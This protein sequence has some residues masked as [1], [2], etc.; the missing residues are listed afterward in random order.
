[1]KGGFLKG[2]V[3][4]DWIRAAMQLRGSALHVAIFVHFIAGLKS[5]RT[6]KVRL[7]SIPIGRGAASRGLASLERAGLIKVRRVRGHWPTVR[8]VETK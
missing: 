4:M 2:P 5:S 7:A 3:S 6:V 8:I 1:M